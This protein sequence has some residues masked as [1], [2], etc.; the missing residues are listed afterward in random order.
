M[1]HLEESPEKVTQTT[2]AS[3]ARTSGCFGIAPVTNSVNLTRSIRAHYIG[4]FTTQVVEIVPV[5]LTAIPT[6]DSCYLKREADSLCEVAIGGL[7]A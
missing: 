1:K 7:T 3:G 2:T 6:L 5:Y 4:A